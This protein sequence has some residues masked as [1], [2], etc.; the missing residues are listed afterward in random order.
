MLCLPASDSKIPEEGRIVS[1]VSIHQKKFEQAGFS[2][3][4][5]ARLL[6]FL[7]NPQNSN[8]PQEAFEDLYGEN[9]TID[10]NKMNAKRRK[11]SI[12]IMRRQDFYE[13]L[14]LEE[15]K[16]LVTE[17]MIKKN[18]KKLAMLHHPDKH[19]EGKYD[20]IAKEQF[21]KVSSAD[22]RSI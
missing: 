4:R 8:S 5:I 3:D 16:H 20:D 12:T 7:K 1:T 2:F 14:N 6:E 10:A 21:L 18:Y 11:K 17:D 13:L 19:E 9:I 22:P 15:E